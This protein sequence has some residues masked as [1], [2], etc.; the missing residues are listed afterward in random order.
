MGC[1]FLLQGNLPDPGIELRCP[2]LAGTFFTIEPPGKAAKHS[3]QIPN[4]SP[5]WI[6]PCSSKSLLTPSR[7]SLPHAAGSWDL[8][9]PLPSFHTELQPLLLLCTSLKTHLP[10]V[11]S[12]SPKNLIW[13]ILSVFLVY[14]LIM[15]LF[16]KKTTRILRTKSV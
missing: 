10:S 5:S 12:S 16:F 15:P 1:H 4:W 2:T 3:K 6:P 13:K 7:P 11:S 8:A 9:P 14:C